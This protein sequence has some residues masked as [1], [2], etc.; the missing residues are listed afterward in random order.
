MVLFSVQIPG[1]LCMLMY[2]TFW[3][4]AFREADEYL[5]H[6][7]Y[8]AALLHIELPFFARSGICQLQVFYAIYF[9]VQII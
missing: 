8:H 6:D 9:F 4:S 1:R 7:S 5:S 2:D 3:S